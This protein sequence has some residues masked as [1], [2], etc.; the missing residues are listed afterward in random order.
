MV[1]AL[2]EHAQE[3]DILHFTFIDYRNIND[4][5]YE[6]AKVGQ[7]Y[8]LAGQF[9]N[10][11]G[12]IIANIPSR[13]P[14]FT[15]V[16]QAPMSSFYILTLHPLNQKEDMFL[17]PIGEHGQVG[18]VPALERAE[19]EIDILRNNIHTIFL[20]TTKDLTANPLTGSLD[21]SSVYL[22]EGR[23]I[24]WQDYED[25]NA[26]AVIRAEFATLRGLEI[27]DTLE[28]TM[29][30]SP[31]AKEYIMPDAS[32]HFPVRMIGERVTIDN[33]WG[34]KDWN[35]FTDA[36]EYD[37]V[38]Y[39]GWRRLDFTGN[40]DEIG[41][42]EIAT[43]Y[44]TDRET[45]F[46]RS[47]SEQIH[48]WRDMETQTVTLEIV[49]I[50]GVIDDLDKRQ[51]F[52]YNNVFVPDSIVPAQW[53]QDVLYRNLSFVLTHP[54]YEEEFLYYYESFFVEHGFWPIFQEHGWESF[55]D[56]VTPIR[57][58]IMVG[59]LTSAALLLLVFLMITGV[60]IL[61]WRKEYAIIRALGLKRERANNNLFFPAIAIGC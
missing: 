14:E 58:A 32:R 41:N 4:H 23:F 42:L 59:I 45:I 49:G 51:T 29:R 17:Y 26:V 61:Q 8:F 16:W 27:G 1:A 20:R 40:Y 46:N 38:Y 57:S 60:Y 11:M 13:L 12:H 15:E 28:V 24:N 7:R 10:N 54:K 9:T 53:T 43:G 5:V 3:G 21:Q 48:D 47:R 2:P 52:L 39:I 33:P 37:G 50:Y 19:E 31:F 18:T 34:M 56:T 55:D 36:I 22:L 30:E 6:Q 25:K 35:P 44:I